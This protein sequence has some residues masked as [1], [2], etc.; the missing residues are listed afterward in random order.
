MCETLKNY[1]PL[2]TLF[3][4]HRSYYILR[5]S[6]NFTPISIQ[7]LVSCN[8]LKVCF[9][10]WIHFTIHFK[11]KSRLST[12]LTTPLLPSTLFFLGYSKCTFFQQFLFGLMT[13]GVLFFPPAV[14][15]P[16]ECCSIKQY[17]KLRTVLGLEPQNL[18]HFHVCWVPGSPEV[19]C[20]S[21]RCI[22]VGRWNHRA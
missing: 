21:F 16:F 20:A 14:G 11:P 3:T 7:G 6:T 2:V 9:W 19:S 5:C 15:G 18:A 10:V 13:R 22:G 12:K 4:H 1:I 17:C 8:I